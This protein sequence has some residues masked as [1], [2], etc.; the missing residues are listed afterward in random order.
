MPGPVIEVNQGDKV[1]IIVTNNLPEPTSVH[2]H[3][4][5]IVADMDGVP[6]M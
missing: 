1:R 4:L 2:W 5:E 6:G 3:G